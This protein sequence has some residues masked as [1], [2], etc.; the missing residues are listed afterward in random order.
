MAM[1][2]F[3]APGYREEDFL[4]NTAIRAD[5]LLVQWREYPAQTI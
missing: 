5:F 3:L 4:A 1:C 2:D